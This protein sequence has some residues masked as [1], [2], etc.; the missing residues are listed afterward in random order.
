[1]CSCTELKCKSLE[2]SQFFFFNLLTPK[3][4]DFKVKLGN[5]IHQQKKNE[6]HKICVSSFQNLKKGSMAAISKGTRRTT[7]IILTIILKLKFNF[8][9]TSHKRNSQ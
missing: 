7:H 5:I 4:D 1:M 2:K 8:F 3:I 6:S 9:F